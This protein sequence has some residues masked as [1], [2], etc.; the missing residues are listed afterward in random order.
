ML[1]PLSMFG[2]VMGGPIGVITNI[3]RKWSSVKVQFGV[4]VKAAL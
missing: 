4:T 2:C 1:Q 3:V